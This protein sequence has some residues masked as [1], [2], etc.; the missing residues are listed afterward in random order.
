MSE[1]KKQPETIEKRVPLINNERPLN[2]S[3]HNYFETIK[4]PETGTKTK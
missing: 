2:E 4:K 3:E 1:N